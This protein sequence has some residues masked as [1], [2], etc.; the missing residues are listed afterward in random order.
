M[1]EE[2]E[3]K[4]ANWLELFFDL[5]FVYAIAKATHV[6]ATPHGGQ[7]PLEDYGLFLLIMIPVWWAWT[8]HTLFTNRFDTGDSTH[9]M[10]TLAQMLAALFLAAFINPDFDATYTGFLLSY[11]AIRLLLIAMYLRVGSKRPG[12]APITKPMSMGFGLG[13]V[14]VA[15][16]CF[17]DPPWRYAVLY[18]GIFIEFMT[19]ILLRSRLSTIPV[20]GHH[21]PERFGLLTIILFGESVVAL[22][23][24]LSTGHLSVGSVAAVVVGF[25][26]LS[27]AWWVYFVLTDEMLVGRDLG[28]GQRI[29]YG[30]LPLYAGLAVLANFVRFGADAALSTGAHLAMGAFGLALFLGALGFIHGAVALCERPRVRL[31]IL[32][33]L[34]GSA[35][36]LGLGALGVEGAGGASH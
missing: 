24:P 14:V 8:G 10:L 3:V 20:D 16:S 33:L 31:A 23:A 11:L 1:T 17:F 7:V 9:R 32:V 21:L 22:G 34:A 13:L 35:A 28:N 5:V 15:C 12:I 36:L 18:A 27:A 6:I 19:P 4:R 26:V 30:H 25:V 2:P 29:I